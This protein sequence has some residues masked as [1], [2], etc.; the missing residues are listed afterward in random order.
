[1]KNIQKIKNRM[2]IR[3]LTLGMMFALCL[4]AVFLP[5]EASSLSDLQQQQKDNQ[6]EQSE[7]TKDLED[8]KK[9]A[10]NGVK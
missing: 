10:A 7:T 6:K 1:M 5:V 3:V 4:S 9:I 2:G 8:A